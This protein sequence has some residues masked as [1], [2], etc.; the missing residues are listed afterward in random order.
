MKH[1]THMVHMIW[2]AENMESL[3]TKSQWTH[4]NG[5]NEAPVYYLRPLH[6]RKMSLGQRRYHIFTEWVLNQMKSD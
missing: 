1:W 3:L 2:N 5:S 6:Q 4:L